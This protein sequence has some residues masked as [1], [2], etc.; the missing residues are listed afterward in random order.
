MRS[1]LYRLLLLFVLS[2]LPVLAQSD[3][4]AVTGTVHDP[5]GAV[6]PEVAVTATNV[7]TGTQSKSATNELGLYSI[8]NL[9]I[10]S[11]KVSFCKTGFKTF[12]RGGLVLLVSQVA[13][14]DVTLQ[15]GTTSEEVVVTASSPILQTQTS[16]ISTN[17]TND[18][19][20]DL[21]LTVD[22]GR[23]LSAFMFAYVP[24]VEGDD[25]SSHINGS[26]AMTKEAM[27]DGTSAVSQ[28]G[29]YIGESSPPLEGVEQL[30]VTSSG[31][32]ADEGRSG[33]G[34]FRYNLKSGTNVFH[35]SAFGFLHNQVF[36]ANTFENK[37]LEAVGIANDPSNADYYQSVYKRQPNSLS[38]WGGSFGGPILKDKT[39]FFVAFERYMSSNFGL[40]TPYSNVPT[41]PFLNGDFSALLDQTVVLGTDGAGNTIYQG[42]I[43]D[44]ATGNVFPGNLIPSDRFSTVSQ[45]IVAIYK[46]QYAPSTVNATNNA[47]PASVNPWAH[48]TEFSVKLDHNL[49]DR[50]HING[51]YIYS[52]NPRMLADQGG[53]WALGTSDGGPFANLY[54]HFVHAPSGRF[55]DSYTFSPNVVNVFNFTLNRFYNPSQAHSRSGNWSETLGLGSFGAGNFPQ[56]SFNGSS[57]TSWNPSYLGSWFND[58]YAAN[59]VIWGDNLT[60]VKGR[61]VWRFGTELR[62]MQ[63]NSHGDSGVLHTTFDAAQ[64]GAPQADYAPYVGYSFA[65]F[66]LG[67]VNSASVSVPNNTY[68]RRKAFSLYASDDYKLTAKLTLSLDLRWDFNGRYHEKYGHWSNFNMDE[69]NPVT[70]IRGTLEFAKDGSDSFERRQYYW[71]FAPHIG[72][73]Y[74]LTP[75]TVVRGSFAISYVPLNLNTWGAIPYSFNPGFVGVNQVLS[76]GTV[77]PAYNWDS[78]YPGTVS[79]PVKDPSYTQWGMVTI[80]PHALMPGN[81]Q[82]WNIGVQREITSD[83]RLDLNFVQSH[84]Y[85]LQSGYLGGNQPKPADYAALAKNGTVWN[86]VSD[87]A[88]AAAAGVPY[89]YAGFQGSAW[90]AITPFPSVAATWG[91]LFY[92]GDPLGNTDYQALQASITKRA[93]NGLSMMASYTLSSTHGDTDT[94]FEELWWTGNLQNVYDLNSE[95]D[96]IASFDQKH[97]VK[98]YVMYELPFGRN[99][100]FFS[101]R[102]A[103]INHLLG[104][105]TIS[106]GFRYASGMPMSIHS[107]NYYP[108][109]NTVYANIV[110]GCK[111][112]ESFGGNIGNYYFNPDCFTN[113]DA[114]SGELGTAGNYLASLRGLGYA[115]EDVGIIKKFSFGPDGRFKLSVRGEFFNVFN[116]HSFSG[117]VTNMS[118]D[119]FGR[120]TDFGGSPDARSGQ[121]GARFTF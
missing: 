40:G 72:A 101:A 108:G 107:S 46:D 105:W 88:S 22:G 117:P 120:I 116:R 55:S 18:A 58:F 75:K 33:G 16:G 82:Q 99:K 62:F 79:T 64:T 48:Q 121:I 61:H 11:Y 7:D 80:D 26:L 78:P 43:F 113:P 81:I 67:E 112:R 8:R 85:H 56:I 39:F 54:D 59:T 23:S 102:N 90:M 31:I 52:S 118:D 66:L 5:S 42:A 70:G 10:G 86:W 100:R 25:Y 47:M 114:N 6:V 63:F 76:T 36:N 73:A 44:P 119:N 13:E 51:S 27:I 96:T 14:V 68:G 74:Q 94:G 9:P 83:T 106:A 20:T 65:S 50:H 19:V 95:R 41:A 29:G 115:K 4:A 98:G 30:E 17:L 109:F 53:V 21:P 38:D 24:G 104:G 97:I 91:P 84:G 1:F 110:S 57:W 49:S 35:G 32:R 87:E 37:Y 111:L 28:L 15:V 34:V 69:T 3:R 71:N 45:K 89:P 2:G 93:R 103:F 92:V 12:E 60:W 77:T